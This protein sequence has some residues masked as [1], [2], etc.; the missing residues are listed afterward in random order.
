M[1]DYVFVFKAEGD[2]TC[3]IPEVMNQKETTDTLK[4]LY[5]RGS[6][7]KPQRIDIIHCP[8]G[9][10]NTIT[11]IFQK[12]KVYTYP[13]PQKIFEV[14]FGGFWSSRAPLSRAIDLKFFLGRRIDINY[15]F[16]F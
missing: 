7:K 6:A 4:A 9:Q 2:E 5:M 16:D 15:T 8:T 1:D 12:S 3:Q 10:K 11:E 14:D 13:A